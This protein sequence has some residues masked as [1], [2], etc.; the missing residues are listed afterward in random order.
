MMLGARLTRLNALGG[1]VALMYVGEQAAPKIY[2][3][4]LN[5]PRTRQSLV[6]GERLVRHGMGAVLPSAVCIGVSSM[7]NKSQ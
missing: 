7:Q 6:K 4:T 1:C 3:I 2:S 5:T